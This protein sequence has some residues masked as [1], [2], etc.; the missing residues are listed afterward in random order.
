MMMKRMVRAVKPMS[1]MGLRPQE[2]TK[3]KVAQYPGIKPA[4][5][6]IRLP[7][8]VLYKLL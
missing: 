2:S 1:W 5:D 8:H 6:R 7:T 3:R 4:T